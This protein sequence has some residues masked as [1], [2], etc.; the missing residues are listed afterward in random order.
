MQ[1]TVECLNL[2]VSFAS[3]IAAILAL[4]RPSLL[5]GTNIVTPTTRFYLLM[6]VARAVPLACL[7]GLLPLFYVDNSVAWIVFTAAVIQALDAILAAR[8]K[9]TGMVAGASVA[10]IVHTWL[11]V[12]ILHRAN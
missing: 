11:G 12:L 3:A 4:S 10:T 1:K 7:S 8:R 6:Y 9:L 2:V 5:P